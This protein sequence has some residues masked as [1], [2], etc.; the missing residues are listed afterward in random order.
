MCHSRTSS[1]ERSS[2]ELK[3]MLL[4]LKE[5]VPLCKGHTVLITKNNTTLGAYINKEGG[6]ESGNPVFY[7]RGSYP[8]TTSETFVSGCVIF[9]AS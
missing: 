8:G 1:S 6:M 4:P 2:K 7:S 9:Q 3:S 5:I